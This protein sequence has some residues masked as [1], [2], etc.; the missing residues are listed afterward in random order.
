MHARI[1]YAHIIPV[2]YVSVFGSTQKRTAKCV[3]IKVAYPA[4]NYIQIWIPHKQ[5]P[6]ST[7]DLN[8]GKNGTVSDQKLFRPGT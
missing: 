7:P 4:L 2:H 1:S 5:N 3:Y 8:L 6:D